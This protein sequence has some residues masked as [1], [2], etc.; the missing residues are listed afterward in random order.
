M[1]NQEEFL[2]VEQSKGFKRPDSTPDNQSKKRQHTYPETNVP[3]H[4]M[5]KVGY[6]KT[7]LKAHERLSN[8]NLAATE[9]SDLGEK[10]H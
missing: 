8:S 5:A 10:K 7:S 9:K 3:D 2:G 4:K 1:N 6:E